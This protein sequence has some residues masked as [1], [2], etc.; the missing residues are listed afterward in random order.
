M[1]VR[2]SDV[3]VI[4]SGGAGVMASVAAAN[5]GAS[6]TIISKEPLGYGTPASRWV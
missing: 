6:V 4:G 1:Q 3:L 5:A 2:R